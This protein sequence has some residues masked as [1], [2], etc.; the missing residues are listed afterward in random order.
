MSE[1][2][3]KAL[4]LTGG[5]EVEG[6][7]EFVD[8]FDKY[9]DILNV[10]NFIMERGKERDSRSHTVC[11]RFSIEGKF[12]L[13]CTHDGILS[14]CSVMHYKVFIFVCVLSHWLYIVARDLSSLSG[15]MGAKC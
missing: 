11:L 4:T 5:P 14:S 8:I 6:T 9:F 10:S 3:A 2:V 1:S 13:K 7:A 15:H 12:L